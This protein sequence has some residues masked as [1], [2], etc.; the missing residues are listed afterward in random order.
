MNKEAL[1]AGV[2]FEV[3]ACTD[4]LLQDWSTLD[5]SEL[6]PRVDSN[7]WYQALFRHDVPVAEAPQRF[8]RLKIYMP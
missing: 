6:L 5:I 4:L 3:E 2:I 7:T 8:M 1:A